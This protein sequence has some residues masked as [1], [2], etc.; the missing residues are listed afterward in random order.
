MEMLFKTSEPV[1]ISAVETIDV[2]EA[3]LSLRSQVETAEIDTGKLVLNNISM[4]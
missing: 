4:S 1:S 3:Q 2:G